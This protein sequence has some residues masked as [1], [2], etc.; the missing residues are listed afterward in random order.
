M[1]QGKWVEKTDTGRAGSHPEHNHPHFTKKV[2]YN[3]RAIGG[4]K[5]TRKKYT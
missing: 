2:P 4:S 3:K 1:A 5:S